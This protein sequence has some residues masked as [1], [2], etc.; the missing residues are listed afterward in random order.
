[1]VFKPSPFTPVS[2]VRLAEIFTE[3]GVPKGLFNVVQGG[4][5]TGQFLCHHPDVAK[6]SF[7]GSVPT[8]IKVKAPS[9]SGTQGVCSASLPGVLRTLVSP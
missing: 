8:G 7:T 9:H 2:V 6:I 5:A 4:A 1:M 3:A